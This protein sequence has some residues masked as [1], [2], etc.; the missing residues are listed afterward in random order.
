MAF[1]TKLNCIRH[2]YGTGTRLRHTTGTRWSADTTLPAEQRPSTPGGPPT[3]PRLRPRPRGEAPSGA[4][5]TGFYCDTTSATTACASASVGDFRYRGSRGNSDL[6]PDQQKPHT[7]L[8]TS[9]GERPLRREGMVRGAPAHTSPGLSDTALPSPSASPGT[10]KNSC[11]GSTLPHAS[12]GR[13]RHSLIA[14]ELLGHLT[15]SR[16]LA[17]SILRHSHPLGWLGVLEFNASGG[18]RPHHSRRVLAI[19]GAGRAPSRIGPRGFG[20]E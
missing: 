20:Y 2:S 11:G 14:R 10:T 4:S 17:G 19:P 6:M 7:K 9:V 15:T 3:T 18:G 5:P 1:S 8:R 16:A 12:P 13:R